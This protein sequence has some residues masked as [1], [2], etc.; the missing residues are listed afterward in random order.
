MGCLYYMLR[1]C[2]RSGGAHFLR[3]LF[4][5]VFSSAFTQ[6]PPALCERTHPGPP[7]C[8]SL[9]GGSS[10]LETSELI[11]DSENNRSSGR[12]DL[13]RRRWVSLLLKNP[14]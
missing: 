12:K 7:S 4:P 9:P 8:A 5:P 2:R 1:G 14:S 11:E 10:S 13:C 6:P 3:R